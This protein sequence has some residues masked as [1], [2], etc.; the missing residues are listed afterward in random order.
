MQNKTIL[1]IQCPKCL[2]RLKMKEELWLSYPYCFNC[3]TQYDVCIKSKDM[4]IEITE[5]NE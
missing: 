2:K 3:N 4:V 1:L 5:K